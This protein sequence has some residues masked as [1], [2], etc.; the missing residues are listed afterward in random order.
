[1]MRIRESVYIL[2]DVALQAAGGRRV[3]R[4]GDLVQRSHHIGYEKAPGD[5]DMARWHPPSATPRPGVGPTVP[6]SSTDKPSGYC[7]PATISLRQARPES[8][9]AHKT[10]CWRLGCPHSFL[11]QCPSGERA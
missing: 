8:A 7:T 5:F 1:M 2:G 4:V 3:M 10:P 11:R 6:A 9:G